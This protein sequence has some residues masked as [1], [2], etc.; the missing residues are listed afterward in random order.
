[1]AQVDHLGAAAARYLLRAVELAQQ[2][3]DAFEVAAPVS[4]HQLVRR[5]VRC[6]NPNS[7]VDQRFEDAQYLFAG[8]VAHAEY[9]GGHAVAALALLP[10]RLHWHRLQARGLVGHDFHA[11]VGQVDGGIALGAQLGQE[12]VVDG[13][14]VVQVDGAHGD[15]ALDPGSTMKVVPVMRDTLSMNSPSSVSTKF[16]SYIGVP[17]SSNT[18]SWA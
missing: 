12:D 5:R 17:L 10:A 4:H 15:L 8:G 6:N 9:A 1:M 14:G 16:T 7:R 3:G 18:G 11:A 13:V 2:A